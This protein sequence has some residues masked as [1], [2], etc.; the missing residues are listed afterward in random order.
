M[1][2]R[3]IIL[4][5]ICLNIA[6]LGA[7]GYFWRHRPQ[8]ELPPSAPTVVTNTRT[9]VVTERISAA[10]AP[11][12]HWREVESEDYRTYIANLKSIGCPEETVRD[13][14]VADVNK[15]F[16]PRFASL[17]ERAKEFKYWQTGN[18]REKIKLEDRRQLRD[19]NREKSELLKDLLGADVDLESRRLAPTADYLNE[20][21]T[22]GFLPESKRT[23]LRELNERYQ[24][25]ER[26]LTQK[27]GGVLTA[28]DRAELKK[29]RDQKQTE[30]AA[31]LT[32]QE[33][34]D[35]ELRNS[36]TA[37][38]MRR[39]YAGVSLSEDEFQRIFRLQKSFDDQ[40]GSALGPIDRTTMDQRTQAQ[41]QLD[42]DIQNVLGDQKYAEFRQSQ[43]PAYRTLQQVARNH[44][45]PQQTV[46]QAYEIK[47]TADQQRRQLLNQPLLPEDR[48]AAL[49]AM[50][51]EIDRTLS[52]LLGPGALREYKESGGA[53]SVQAVYTAVSGP[54]GIARRAIS[55]ES[56][57]MITAPIVRESAVGSGAIQ[58]TPPK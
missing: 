35:Y 6:S 56:G 10:T 33:M 2:T 16:A 42:G 58:V 38:N 29:L 37:D 51:E 3:N 48:S 43:D 14:I 32:P 41:R 27:A 39:R 13:I 17:T 49:R 8:I 54:D 23:Q 50:N 34:S 30:L 47:K 1:N 9:R 26:D 12:F 18:Q 44:N 21:A 5:L 24:D 52:S 57:D 19:L 45:L 15:L 25:L 11:A 55:F 4:G 53:D 22:L 36:L 20:E 31:L 28:K 40:F 46:S 7:A